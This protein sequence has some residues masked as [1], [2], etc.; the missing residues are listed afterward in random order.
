MAMMKLKNSSKDLIHLSSEPKEY[1][2]HLAVL[3]P[4]LALTI[5]PYNVEAAEL[6]ASDLAVLGGTDDE[7]HF[8]RMYYPSEPFL[9]EVSAICTR[10]TGWHGSLKAL[11]HYVMGGVVEAEFR[12]E[13][14]TKI[15]CLMAMDCLLN[16]PEM[17]SLPSD[18]LCFSR[19]VKVLGFLNALVTSRTGTGTRFCD[20]LHGV[21]PNCGFP[22]GTLNVDHSKLQTFLNGKVFFNHFIRIEVK[23]SIPMLVHAWNRGAAIICQ[24][25]TKGIDYVLSVILPARMEDETEF[26]PLHDEWTDDQC[27]AASRRVS[28]ILINSRNYES[29]KTQFAAAWAAKFS[30]KNFE[31]CQTAKKSKRAE[32]VESLLAHEDKESVDEESDDEKDFADDCRVENFDEL[33]ESWN[34]DE[35][36]MKK[37]NEGEKMQID[38]EDKNIEKTENVFMSLVQDFG[39][40]SKNESSVS[41]GEILPDFF[42]ARVL[43]SRSIQYPRPEP[44]TQFIVVL[45]GIGPETYRFLHNNAVNS[46]DSYTASDLELTRRYL[47][48]LQ[49]T[50]YDYIENRRQLMSKFKD[51]KPID[52]SL[53]VI[54]EGLPLVY[55]SYRYTSEARR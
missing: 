38:K 25:G 31:S 36:R 41:I 13:L 10:A 5:G 28:Y 54:V 8:L 37:A 7:R 15:T 22:F 35:F 42:E 19:A 29:P 30:I 17:E 12:G 6:V 46:N 49:W 27:R 2:Q 55:N 32:T 14:L 50:R 23:V 53:V 40:K 34:P 4:R 11:N 26:G 33:D 1:L 39:N 24:T 16:S 48:R 45:K 3:A 43:R 20:M 47:N 51:H 9:G 44:I 21:T 18:Q 52:K